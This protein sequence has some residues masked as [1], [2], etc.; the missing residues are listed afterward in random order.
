MFFIINLRGL[1]MKKYIVTLS[2]D[3]REALGALTSG[4]KQKS[5]K[6]LNAL[7]LLGCIELQ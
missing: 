3:E 1:N 2:K 6:I 4:G 7:I 5:Q